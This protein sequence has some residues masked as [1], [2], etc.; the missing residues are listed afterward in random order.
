MVLRDGGHLRDQGRNHLVIENG[1]V[2][3]K[4]NGESSKPTVPC[5]TVLA[6][7]FAS[8]NSRTDV[9]RAIGVKPA[10][11]YQ[12]L[13]FVADGIVTHDSVFMNELAENFEVELPCIAVIG[14]SADA[15]K[16]RMYLPLSGPEVTEATRSA[17]NVLVSQ[18]RFS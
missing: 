12:W 1:V 10:T 3:L 16:E 17:W 2:S 5:E 9:A 18:H 14:L 7:A 13:F 8:I 11:V 6:T 4:G 15:T